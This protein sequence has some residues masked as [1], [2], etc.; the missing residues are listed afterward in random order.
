VPFQLKNAVAPR[1]SKPQ[2]Q[3]LWVPAFAGTT[4][5]K[6]LLASP[7]RLAKQRLPG[8]LAVA[9]TSVLAFRKPD[10]LGGHSFQDVRMDCLK[11]EETLSLLEEYGQGPPALPDASILS[12]TAGARGGMQISST[13]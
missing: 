11:G 4:R 5:R 2:Q 1:V 8:V 6:N 13:A 7:P 10:S 9:G 12:K 3:W